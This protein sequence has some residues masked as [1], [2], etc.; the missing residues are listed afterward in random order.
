MQS[1]SRIAAQSTDLGDRGVWLSEKPCLPR[2]EGEARDR[3]IRGVVVDHFHIAARRDHSPH[4]SFGLVRI[5][6]GHNPNLKCAAA[7]GCRTGSLYPN[8]E[9]FSHSLNP[10]S[11]DEMAFG[12]LCGPI[13]AVKSN[14]YAG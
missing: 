12:Q 10:D 1:R 8:K 11:P 9:C 14:S 2:S 3:F 5:A 4:S 6:G 7:G 13:S